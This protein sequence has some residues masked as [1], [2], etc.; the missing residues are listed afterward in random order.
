MIVAPIPSRESARL[1]ALYRSH[2]LDT[3]SEPAFDELARLAAYVCRTPIAV[4]SLVDATRQWFKSVV[5]LPY[6]ESPRSTAFCAHTILGTDLFIVEDAGADTRFADHPWVVEPPSIRFYAG[7]PLITP[8]GY[9]IGSLAV[10]DVATR[11]LSSEQLACLRTIANQ[12][13]AQLELRRAPRS[14]SRHEPDRENETEDLGKVMQ[15]ILDR[16]VHLAGSSYFAAL[17]QELATAT[18]ADHA[19]CARVLPRGNRAQ[20]LALWSGGSAQPNFEYDLAGTPCEQVSGG[21][22]CHYQTGVQAL[23]P[24]DTLL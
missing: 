22:P 4:I 12:V 15:T 3:P 16:T 20:T 10:M 8:D 23:F 21:T 7:V 24:D 9:A 19:F 18:G 1:D 2:I 14:D 13:M 5:G 17:I 11:T 6:T